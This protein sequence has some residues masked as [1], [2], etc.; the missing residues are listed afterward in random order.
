MNAS[1]IRTP[2]SRA[3]GLGSAASGFG[4]W[5]MLRVT[6]LPLIPLFIYFLFEMDSI[7]AH[8]QA[9][10][11]GWLSQPLPGI[12]VIVFIICA[13]YH[14]ALGLHEIIEDYVHHHGWKTGLA[15]LNKFFFFSLGIACVYATLYIS[16]ILNGGIHD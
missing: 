9:D 13:F 4:A 6:S 8:T 11:I 5:W 10:F 12:A 2:L 14:A 16:L 15:L 3:K 1:S 7:V